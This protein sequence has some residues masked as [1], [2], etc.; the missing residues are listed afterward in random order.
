MAS[1]FSFYYHLLMR[2]HLGGEEREK[3]CL[4]FFLTDTPWWPGLKREVELEVENQ[5]IRQ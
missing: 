4:L 3:W 2:G 5:S 1:S